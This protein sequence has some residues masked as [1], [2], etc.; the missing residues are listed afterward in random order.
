[1][2]AFLSGWLSFWANDAPSLSIMALAPSSA[3]LAFSNAYPLARAI[4]RCRIN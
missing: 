2:T 3:I 4:H 1:M